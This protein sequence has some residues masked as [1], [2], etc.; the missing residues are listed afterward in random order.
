MYPLSNVELIGNFVDLPSLKLAFE[1]QGIQ[2]YTSVWYFGGSL[3]EYEERDEEKRI[4]CAK[5]GNQDRIISESSIKS[6]IESPIYI[7]LTCLGITLIEIPYWWDNTIESLQATIHQSRPELIKADVSKW[8]PI[9]K[10][11]PDG[12]G[13]KSIKKHV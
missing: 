13:S 10:T 5:R 9:P 4:A 1:F 2:H 11:M 3:R 8:N 12:F 7:M 6:P